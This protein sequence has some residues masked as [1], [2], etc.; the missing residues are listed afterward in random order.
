MAGTGKSHE[1][2]VKTVNSTFGSNSWRY[3]RQEL[4]RDE[5][6]AL[7]HR[8]GHPPQVTHFNKN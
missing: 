1:L 2:L 7:W 3:P 5:A 8:V 4:L 6:P